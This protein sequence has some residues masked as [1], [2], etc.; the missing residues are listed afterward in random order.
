MAAQHDKDVITA[1]DTLIDQEIRRL[2][3]PALHVDEGEDMLLA[4]GVAPHHGAALGIVFRD[5]VHH[6]VA[7]VEVVGIVDA[8]RL[9]LPIG[10]VGLVNVAQIDIPHGIKEPLSVQAGQN[11]PE[12]S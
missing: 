5:V 2:V 3:G 4:F 10:S 11:T 6:V 12:V 8:E 7:E 1:L 9:K